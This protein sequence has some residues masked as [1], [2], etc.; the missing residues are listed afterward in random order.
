MSDYLHKC[1]DM[2]KQQG[3]YF[4]ILQ[5]MNQFRFYKHGHHKNY[6]LQTIKKKWNYQLCDVT[7]QEHRICCI[8][9]H[10]SVIGMCSCSSYQ[11]ISYH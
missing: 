2:A 3:F 10:H 6:S 5:Y 11:I 1:I 7:Q 4:I 8:R 9:M